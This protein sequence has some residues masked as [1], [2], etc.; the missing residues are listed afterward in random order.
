MNT[1]HVRIQMPQGAAEILK[2]LHDDG[3][4]AY[5]VGGCVRDSLLGLEPKDWDICTSATPDET[6]SCMPCSHIIRTGIKHG[7]VTIV[8]DE[9]QYEVTTYRTD[10]TYS[11]HRHPDSVK[12]TTSL[13]EDLSRRD[14]TMNAMAYNDSD[15]LIDPFG[16]RNDLG[17]AVIRC[18]GHPDNRFEEDALRVLRALRFS[19][20]YGFSVHNSTSNAIHRNA[21]SLRHIA[22]ERI[23]DELVKL[24]AGK[25][26]CDVL[27]SY[28]DVI[29]E[30]IPEINP[31][32]GFAQ[33]NP[34]HRYTVYGHIAHAVG[35]YNGNDTAV[36]V[37]LLLHDIGKPQCYTEDE[38]GGHFKGH[39]AISAE[40]TEKVLNRLRF[41]NKSKHDITQLVLYHDAEFIPTEKFV[42]KWLNRIGPEQ[43]E[44]LIEVRNADIAAHA[45]FAQEKHYSVTREIAAI[46]DKVIKEQQC[47]TIKDL[48]MNGYDIMCL[49]VKEGK[50]VGDT[51]T[52]LLNGVLSGDLPNE[53]DELRHAAVRY[54]GP[55]D[56]D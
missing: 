35:S 34:Y 8:T 6:M 11:D 12:F 43:F 21:R 15:G 7:T 52:F 1:D 2:T 47:F 30:I 50:K 32:R 27:M 51:L 4:E 25:N 19:S 24:L 38:N 42:K 17:N 41:D 33:N 48:K 31:C 39:G 37:A 46:L 9:G 3:F 14:F 18:V 44:R 56:K 5:I 54:I 45:P 29:C 55:I 36:N 16:G 23:R 40:I 10:G 13:T 22:K 26:A 53:F 28:S 49:G 20:V